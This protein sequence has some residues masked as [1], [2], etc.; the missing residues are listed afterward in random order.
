[1]S[2]RVLDRGSTTEFKCQRGGQGLSFRV[3]KGVRT[4]L[5]GSRQE[6]KEFTFRV[7]GTSPRID[8]KSSTKDFKK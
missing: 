3:P 6:S 7:L 4:E 1:M 8:I 2:F 5:R